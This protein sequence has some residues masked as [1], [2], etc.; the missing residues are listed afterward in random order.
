MHSGNASLAAPPD[1]RRIAADRIPTRSAPHWAS[2]SP[3]RIG[4]L[5]IGAHLGLNGEP[6]GNNARLGYSGECGLISA[7]SNL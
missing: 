3:T 6:W 1:F 4:R 2:R 7:N 5:F